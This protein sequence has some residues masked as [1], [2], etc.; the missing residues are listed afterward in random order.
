M[1]RVAGM[2]MVRSTGISRF[3]AAIGIVACAAVWRAERWTRVA[4]I[5]LF[6]GCAWLVWVMQSRGS[7][8][9]FVAALSVVMMLLRGRARIIGIMALALTAGAVALNFVSHETLRNIW[10]HAARNDSHLMQMH[11]RAGIFHN[12]W[13]AILRAP[14]I[15]YGPQAD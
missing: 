5:A 7:L 10:S 1:P 15:G 6:A 9:S 14:I 12:T 13:L 11:G 4:W 8:A 3:A 2:P